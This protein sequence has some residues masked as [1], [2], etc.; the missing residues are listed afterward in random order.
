MEAPHQGK[1]WKKWCHA[2]WYE[3]CIQASMFKTMLDD[4]L[5]CI[6]HTLHTFGE[7]KLRYYISPF[8]NWHFGLDLLTQ[9]STGEVHWGPWSRLASLSIYES[10]QQTCAMTPDKFTVHVA[11]VSWWCEHHVVLFFVM[12]AKGEWMTMRSMSWLRI[13]W[14][15]KFLDGPSE[16]SYYCW[17][18]ATLDWSYK[19]NY[20]KNIYI[21][22]SI[23]ICVCII[24][25]S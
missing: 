4:E 16:V 17:R 22:I 2:F 7:S 3:W 1:N 14:Y 19:Y 24:N 6:S 23:F 5:H 25:Q 10:C 12:L 9:E 21:Y 15:S 18:L 8:A 13:R 11:L 20:K